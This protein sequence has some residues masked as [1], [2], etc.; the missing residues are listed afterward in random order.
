MLLTRQD[1]DSRFI[2]RSKA[3][4]KIIRGFMSSPSE[5]NI[6]LQVIK[7]FL[8]LQEPIVL[9]FQAEYSQIKN[10]DYMI[11]CPGKGTLCA[12]GKNWNFCK[13][14]SGVRFKSENEHLVIDV[15]IWKLDK[16]RSFDILRLSEY[17]ESIGL[18]HI[19]FMSKKVSLIDESSLQIIVDFLLVSKLIFI[20]N[21]F[22]RLYSIYENLDR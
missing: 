2:V 3:T 7:D 22:P 11:G 16:P 9:K 8:D 20:S 15:P 4:S 13:H 10:W 21:D 17:F 14:G 6:T 5:I 1:I 18:V 19:D 12:L